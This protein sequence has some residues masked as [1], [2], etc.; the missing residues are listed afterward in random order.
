MRVRH[1]RAIYLPLFLTPD[2]HTPLNVCECR[3]LPPRSAHSLTPQ[4]TLSVCC[5]PD[6]GPPQQYHNTHTYTHTP[7]L[8]WLAVMM[9]CAY[10]C[11]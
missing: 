7:H 11:V 3:N 4:H 6:E 2:L 9:S 1:N 5:G 10:A 8:H